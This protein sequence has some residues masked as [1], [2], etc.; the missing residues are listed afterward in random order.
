MINR[1]LEPTIIKYAEEYP[2]L[3][4]V[5]PRQS[6]K[7][8][9]AG[10][11]FPEHGYVSLE[12]LDDRSSA[13][14]DPRG[15]LSDHPAPL[16]IDE[17]QRVPALFSYLQEEA[18]KTALPAR[19]VLTGSQQFLLMEKISQ[20]LAGRIVYFR[21]FPFTCNELYW[22]HIDKTIKGIITPGNKDRHMAVPDT[23]GVIFKG[24]YPR[25]H[26]RSLTPTKWLENYVST[27][28]E[29]DIRQLVNV[30]DL[31]TFENF[32]KLTAAQAG[33]LFNCS[34][35]SN[36][37][38]VSVPTVKRWLSLLETSGIVFILPPHHR[39]FGKR[40]VKT[41][42]I[43]FVDSGLLCFLLSIRKPDELKN[44][45]LY[46]NIFENFVISEFYKRIFHI[47]EMPPLYFWRD[48]LGNEIDLAVDLGELL[49]PI[50]IKSSRTFSPALSHGLKKWMNLAVGQT[51][52]GLVV[53]DGEKRFGRSSSIATVPWWMI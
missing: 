53:Y 11:V 14:E 32:L 12:N 51:G 2:V 30:S 24:M 42:K 29:R 47:G 39:N 49:Y 38:G 37:L 22:P 23:H 21:L 10:K 15:F 50:E 26:D 18:D 48:R 1:N 16:I 45:P 20:S 44:H 34:S 28:V 41:P 52:E 9:L 46:G 4:I 7:T 43:Y 13:M 8:T 31:R 36:S 17:I 40:V 25:I 27:Y 3:A 19:Y 5:G 35:I 33:Q 6:G